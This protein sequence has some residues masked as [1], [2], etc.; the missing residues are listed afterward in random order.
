M[1]MQERRG[2]VY[3]QPAH[4]V[5]LAGVAHPQEVMLPLAQAAVT[6]YAAPALA[7]AY[8]IAA[9]LEPEN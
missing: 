6:A 1:I 2:V 7:N 4:L 5:C 9:S 8:A 3:L